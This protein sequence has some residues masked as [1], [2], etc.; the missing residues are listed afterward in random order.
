M[1][2][3]DS[4][5]PYSQALVPE[6]LVKLSIEK[7][8]L[9]EAYYITPGERDDDRDP[10]IFVTPDRR[11]KMARSYAIDM[12]HA[13]PANPIG[14][15]G[16]MHVAA[17][18]PDTLT[19]QEAYIADLRF[20]ENHQLVDTDELTGSLLDQEEYVAWLAAIEDSVEFAGFIAP[21]AEFEIDEDIP[22][23]VFYGNPSLYPFLKKLR[24]RSNK[25]MKKFMEREAKPD[26]TVE[27]STVDEQKP[28]NK[29]GKESSDLSVEFSNK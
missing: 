10:A 21:E 12:D 17:L 11:L 3:R 28:I 26:M 22:K 1:K 19:I 8:P 14:L 27:S 6:H 15:V 13:H 16:V 23:G 4:D 2:R 29:K 18:N 20:I 5:L 9:E 25:I 7:L 24:K